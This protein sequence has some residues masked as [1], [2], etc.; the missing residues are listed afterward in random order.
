[1]QIMYLLIIVNIVATLSMLYLKA[2]A[3][4]K[5]KNLATKED[6]GE[7]TRIVKRIETDHLAEIEA[8]KG[9]QQLRMAAVDKRLQAHQEAFTLWRRMLSKLETTDAPKAIADCST[10]WEENCLYLEFSA[11]QAFSGAF[12]NAAV[13]HMERQRNVTDGPAAVERI[14]EILAAGDIIFKAVQLPPLTDTEKE[15]AKGGAQ[16][17]AVGTVTSTST[18]HLR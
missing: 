13:H 9:K 2:Y 12:A 3:G 4:E 7:I 8:L 10:W 18:T 11:R 17:F 5:G 16:M 15:A 6:I 14:H 1:M